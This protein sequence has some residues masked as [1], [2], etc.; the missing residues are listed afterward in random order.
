MTF[1]PQRVPNRF[2]CFVFKIKSLGEMKSMKFLTSNVK[3][4]ELTPSTS[5]TMVTLASVSTLILLALSLG[6]CATTS[7][8]SGTSEKKYISY[9]DDFHVREDLV[10]EDLD[11][12]GKHHQ[13]ESTVHTGGLETIF[14]TPEQAAKRNLI[15]QAIAVCPLGFRLVDS[16]GPVSGY[17]A[18]GTMSAVSYAKASSVAICARTRAEA[19]REAEASR[20]AEAET[21]TKRKSEQQRIQAELDEKLKIEGLESLRRLRTVMDSVAAARQTLINTKVGTT[22][23][24]WAVADENKPTEARYHCDLARAYSTIEEIQGYGWVVNSNPMID[25]KSESGRMMTVQGLGFVKK[26]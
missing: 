6:A 19:N 5:T 26:K 14:N 17:S 1:S 18:S 16:K 25:V 24:C 11:F 10:D 20:L 12:R 8:N 23:K 3:A 13:L 9:Q 2:C 22:M 15:K 4:I 7:G 21:A